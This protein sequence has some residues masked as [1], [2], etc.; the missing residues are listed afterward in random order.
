MKVVVSSISFSKNL[1][2]VKKLKTFFP[3]SVVNELGKRY[4][5]D[6]LIEYFKDADAVILAVEKVD[7]KL[8]RALPKLRFISKYGVGLDSVDLDACKKN[9]VELGWTGGVNKTSVAEITIGFM[10]ML[11]RN[12]YLTSN[13]LKYNSFWNKNGGNQLSNKTIG[14]IGLGHVG[15]ELVRLLQ[16][17]ECNIIANDINDVSHF[18]S[19]NNIRLVDKDTIYSLSDII[20]IHTPLTTQTKNL[21]DLE[22]FHKMKK[23]SFIINTARGGII[24]ENDLQKALIDKLILGAALDVYENEPSK[25]RNLLKIDNLICTPHIAGNAL[26]AINNMGNSAIKHLIDFKNN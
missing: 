11:I 21:I 4:E 9:G 8:L 25:N 18:A 13:Q 19:Q 17:F 1:A 15:K 20:T 14:I 23:T 6:D 2:L 12:L 3:D 5:G 10:L 22:V 26:E 16:N 24:R 7:D